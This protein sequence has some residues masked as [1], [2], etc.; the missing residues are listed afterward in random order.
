MTKDPETS[1]FLDPSILIGSSSVLLYNVSKMLLFAFAFG[2]QDFHISIELLALL[3][4]FVLLMP[5]F[6]SGGCDTPLPCVGTI[7]YTGA[8]GLPANTLSRDQ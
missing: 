8:T 5:C 1:A 6:G 7:N 3:Y 2:I 4:L